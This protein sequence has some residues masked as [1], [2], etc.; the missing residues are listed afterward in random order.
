MLEDKYFPGFTQQFIETDPGVQ[1][2]TW[3]GGH[4]DTAVLLLHGHPETHLIWRFLAPR[5]AEQYT[6]VMTD[7]RGYGDS[8]KPKGLPDHA[9]YSKRVMGE[10]HF[11]VMNK[12]GFEKFHL[13]GHDRGA[14]VC[15][16]MI[17]D[18]PERILTCTMMD[19]LP[20]LEMYADTN[21]E[22]ATKYYHWFFYIQPNGFPETLLGAAPEYFIRFNLERK[23]GPTARANFP[24]DVMQEYIRC[25]SDPAT[26][27]G[28]SEDYRASATIDRE[29][30]KKDIDDKVV[31]KTPLLVMWGKNGVVGKL[32]D[33]LAGWQAKAEQVE[34]Y[35]IDNC[36]HFVPE[37]QPDMVNQHIL[38][39]LVKYKS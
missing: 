1:I 37:E 25:F 9:N 8:S 22:F 11:T 23:I 21:E 14:R 10:D 17:V 3:I 38:D 30:D 29:F 12:L 39:F 24:E 27:H 35:G 36:G 13:I 20:T 5:L 28:I 34:G 2:N 32:W 4:G 18:K 33:V 6:V 26:I 15:H 31:I 19:I 7:L 16:R